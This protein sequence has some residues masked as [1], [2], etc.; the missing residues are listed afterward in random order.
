MTNNERYAP[1]TSC[2][3]ALEWMKEKIMK[4]WEIGHTRGGRGKGNGWQQRQEET[5]ISSG[6]CTSRSVG[7]CREFSRDCARI[8]MRRGALPF[9]LFMAARKYSRRMRQRSRQTQSTCV[10]SSY[11]YRSFLHHNVI[12]TKIDCN[13]HYLDAELP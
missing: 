8:H 5:R 1:E 6:R 4:K 9:F 12:Q 13:L 10:S 3:L 2:D 11:D 7:C